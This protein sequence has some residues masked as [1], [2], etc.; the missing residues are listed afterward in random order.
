MVASSNNHLRLTIR[1]PLRRAILRQSF[2]TSCSVYGVYARR[3]LRL[4]ELLR[5]WLEVPLHDSRSHNSTEHLLSSHPP[6]QLFRSLPF[7]EHLAK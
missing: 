2:H 7:P 3:S 6:G 1:L 5:Q 4:K